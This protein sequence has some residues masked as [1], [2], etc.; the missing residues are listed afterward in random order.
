MKKLF[1]N[2]IAL[3]IAVIL[4]FGAFL[5]QGELSPNRLFSIEASAA[6]SYNPD[7]AIAYAAANWDNGVGLCAEF[8]SNCLTAGGINIMQ[9]K[10]VN[11][12]KAL[13][14]GGYGTS[15]KL[16]SSSTQW[17]QVAKMSDNAGKVKVGDPLFT[18]CSVCGYTHA[19]IC[20]GVDSS[21]YIT[22]YAH[23]SAKNNKK[24]YADCTK[25]SASYVS[26]Y[27][28]SMNTHTHNY[29]LTKTVPATCTSDG[30]KYF[31]C[32]CGL[33]RSEKYQSALGHS[34]TKHTNSESAH[35]H[36]KI[37]SCSNGC[38]ATKK[39]SETSYNSSCVQCNPSAFCA[40]LGDDFY[41]VI[42]NTGHWKPISKTQGTNDISLQT[43]DGSSMQKWR[44][45]RQS[46]GAYVISS[47]YDGTV[48]EMTD[49]KRDVAG[50]TLSAKEGFW[51]GYYQQWYLIPQ[52][53]GYI[54]LSKHYPGEQWVM[55]LSGDN[56]KDGMNITIYPRNN[57]NA[58]IWSVY[59]RDEVQLQPAKLSATV[60]MDKVTFTWPHAYGASSYSMKLFTKEMYENGDRPLM[61]IENIKSGHSI[62][63]APGTYYAYIDSEDY[64]SFIMSNVVKFTITEKIPEKPIIKSITS[65]DS[66]MVTVRWT[67]CKRAN[68][69][70]LRFYKDGEHYK[71]LIG[72]TKDTV[73]WY[74]LPSGTYTV[75]VTAEGD[76]CWKDGEMSEEFTVSVKSPESPCTCPNCGEQFDNT[77]MLNQHI[78]SCTG[79]QAQNSGGIFS[80]LFR[81]IIFIFQLIFLPFVL[82]F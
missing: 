65:D 2:S 39:S 52:G 14:D 72:V 24:Y 50:E 28:V 78:S 35:P 74:A 34:Y 82:L 80:L 23:N 9:K 61:T 36:Y 1:K 77:D 67:E 71:S 20:G 70:S 30:Y 18:Y 53:N 17:G 7:A 32:S 42:L 64:Y 68:S 62:E 43:E 19:V 13:I 37:Y 69:Y 6:S 41:G 46:D 60:D 8:V 33:S 12:R 47:C 59:R 57:S 45:Q 4:T 56:S 58:Q 5:P 49:G 76:G 81:I 21:G 15:Y 44:F 10:V 29:T 54:F 75:K 22:I 40:N 25:H 73:Y 16:T 27:S 3:I 66:G 26:I 51:G 48:L 79:N 55:D 31:S 11:L 38:G 63:L